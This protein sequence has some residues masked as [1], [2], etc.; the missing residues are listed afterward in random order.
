VDSQAVTVVIPT[1]NRR[2]LLLRTL[3]SVLGQRDITVRVVVVDDG[4]MDGTADAVRGLGRNDV[5]VLRHEQ[6]KGVSAARNAGLA[7]AETTWVAFVDDDDLWAPDKISAQ[8]A[9]LAKDPSAG[10]SCVGAVRVDSDLRVV[11]HHAPPASGRIENELLRR[12]SIPGGGSGTVALTSLAREIGGFDE[13]ISIVADW[14]FYLRLSLQSPIA[15][16]DRPLLAQ[17][18]HPDSMYFDP[19]GMIRELYY[20]EDKYQN[21]PNGL[22]LDADHAR[23][24]V[25]F[26]L[27]AH[28]LGNRRTAVRL[29]RRGL[30]EAGPAQMLREV[31]S[32]IGPMLR[33]RLTSGA[34][35]PFVYEESADSWLR[36]LAAPT[37]DDAS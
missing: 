13:G 17:Y 14:D 28:R 29:L 20:L 33:R 18:V 37:H 4:G 16:V 24:F 21:L 12:N 31:Q 32:R 35:E 25:Y 23:W 22:S 3:A 34:Q 11:S 2:H 1:H 6:S 19:S 27:M 7:V 5:L 9:A 36:A 8:L 30:S 15:V 26:A 10:W